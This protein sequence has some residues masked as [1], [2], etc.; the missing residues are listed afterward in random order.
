MAFRVRY[1]E[2]VAEQHPK[3][4]KMLDIETS[5][6]N[7]EL[8]LS[9]LEYA[10]NEAEREKWTGLAENPLAQACAKRAQEEGTSGEGLL[11]RTWSLYQR[12]SRIVRYI[13][14][15]EALLEAMSEWVY[16]GA[17][18]VH[19]FDLQPKTW[20]E[21]IGHN[22]G[23]IRID[24]QYY[25][26]F[27]LPQVLDSIPELNSKSKSMLDILKKVLEVRE[28]FQPFFDKL[29]AIEL[30]IAQARDWLSKDGT[31]SEEAY[32]ARQLEELEKAKAQIPDVTKLYEEIKA[33]VP[34]VSP[35][36]EVTPP[37]TIIEQ[38]AEPA[39]SFFEAEEILQEAKVE[40]IAPPPIEIPPVEVAVP[41]EA[42]AL[43]KEIPKEAYLPLGIVAILTML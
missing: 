41:I 33:I 30:R 38:I 10:V 2:R 7:R 39:T 6:E 26:V 22:L 15:I 20:I 13:A 42:P 14:E 25:R 23:L 11:V 18:P 36:V 16:E 28:P 34:F 35:L 21:N 4:L 12:T 8:I 24:I 19:S 29:K 9:N 1:F 3:V 43:I 5:A 27:I 17:P 31:P 37:V 40:V 32:L